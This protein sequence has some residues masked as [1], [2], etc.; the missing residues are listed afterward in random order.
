MKLAQTS[1]EISDRAKQKEFTPGSLKFNSEA[2]TK[3]V[4]VKANRGEK[5]FNQSLYVVYGEKRQNSSV[6]G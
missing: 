3:T 6:S 1:K 4:H 2:E 5:V